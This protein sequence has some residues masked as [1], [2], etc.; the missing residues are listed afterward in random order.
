MNAL[1]HLGPRQH[2][3]VVV[4][5]QIVRVIGEPRPPKVRLGERV[6]LDHRPHGA[7]EEEDALAEQAIESGSGV[8]H[9]RIPGETMPVIGSRRQ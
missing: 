3:D 4:A 8:V 5:L 1:D 9:R 6:A 7:V 2:Q